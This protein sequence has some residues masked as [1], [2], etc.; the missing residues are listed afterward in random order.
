[1]GRNSA[2]GGATPTDNSGSGNETLT[3]R[4]TYFDEAG[5]PYEQQQDVFMATGT[6]VPS[7]RAITHTGGGLAHN[8]TGNGHTAT[9]TIS[10]SPGPSNASYVLSRTVY[11][12]AGRTVA[13]MQ[14]LQP[15]TS[16]TAQTA[17]AFDGAN[18]RISETERAWQ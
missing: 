13:T 6:S 2:S 4:E 14:D 9:V 7:T 10:S 1:M 11:D 18:R 8:S 17:Y 15:S 16:S 5:R 12:S 3:S